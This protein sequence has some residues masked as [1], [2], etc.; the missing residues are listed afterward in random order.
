MSE[1]VTGAR[2]DGLTKPTPAVTR[3]TRVLGV[4]AANPARAF[5]L[6]ELAERVQVSRSSLLAILHALVDA[7]LLARHPRHRTYTLGAGAIALGHA[8]LVQHPGVDAA[9]AEL[10]DL[11]RALGVECLAA[12]PAGDEVVIVATAGR[13]GAATPEVRVGHRLPLAAPLGAV[14]VAW[15]PPDVVD[16]WVRRAGLP[17]TPAVDWSEVLSAIRTRGYGITA[18]SE[19]RRRLGKVLDARS[20]HGVAASDTEVVGA[21]AELGAEEYQVATLGRRGLRVST[22]AAPVFDAEGRVTLGIAAFGWSEPLRAPE[23]ERL[24]GRVVASARAVTRAVH[25]REPVP[26]R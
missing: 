5:T 24:A 6:T 7:G 4:L 20:V 22:L 17:A 21:V 12:V 25:G 18:D 16:A 9:R 19:P 26:S 2:G 23:I 11:A 13:P 10:P 3:A 14:Y 1:S 15:S 8:A